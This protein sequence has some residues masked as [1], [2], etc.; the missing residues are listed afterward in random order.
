MPTG[1]AWFIDLQTGEVMPV[2]EHEG[3]VRANPARY[4]VTAR[5]LLGQERCGVLRQVLARGFA[6]VRADKHVVVVEFQWPRRRACGVLR[7]F[8]QTHGFIG[9][10]PV[11]LQDHLQRRNLQCLAEEFLSREVPPEHWEPWRG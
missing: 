6:R 11:R 4:R 5:A 10:R 7:D 9:R 2:F 3:A 1:E 8:L